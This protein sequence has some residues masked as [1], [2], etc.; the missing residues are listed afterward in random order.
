[1][2][3]PRPTRVLSRER[4]LFDQVR[5]IGKFDQ[6]AILAVLSHVIP[7]L[8]D[9]L[10]PMRG[11]G[12]VTVAGGAYLGR[13]WCLMKVLRSFSDAPVQCYHLGPDELRHKAVPMLRDMGV[14]FVDAHPMMS[15]ENY[16]GFGGWEAKSIGIKYCPFQSVC[17]MDA[18]CIPLVDPEAILKHQDF[19]TGFLAFHDIQA[20]RKNNM[21]FPSL[22]L[23]YDPEW[24]EA[25]AGQFLVDRSRFWREIQL[26]SFMNGRP[27]PFHELAM[28]DKTLLQLSCMKLGTPFNYGGKPAW[29]GGAI[30][31]FLTDGTPAFLHWMEEKRKGSVP[32]EVAGLLK[33]FQTL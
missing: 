32:N 18:D 1:M 26:Y 22:G 28:G 23:M 25:E 5:R 3:V 30:R 10:P 27:K 17:F 20:C 15:R 14:E 24:I 21:L 16:Q 4:V 6:G 9:P 11:F 33:E 7:L 31:H 19:S 29:E 2:T 12:I 13:F 8:N